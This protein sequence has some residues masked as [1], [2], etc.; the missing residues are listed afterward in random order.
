VNLAHVPEGVTDAAF[1]PVSLSQISGAPIAPEAFLTKLASA[2]AA[3]EAKLATSGFA[4][5]RADW[6]QQA[7]RLGETITARTPKDDVTGIF[8]TIDSDGQLILQTAKGRQ[9]ISAADVYFG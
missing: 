2:F 8:E 5:I 7:A 4:A 1:A 3:Q 9:A 6:L